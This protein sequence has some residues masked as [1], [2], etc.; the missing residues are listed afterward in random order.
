MRD[1]IDQTEIRIQTRVP[2]TNQ[3]LIKNEKNSIERVRELKR[4]TNL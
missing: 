1:T 2:T 3:I 4:L